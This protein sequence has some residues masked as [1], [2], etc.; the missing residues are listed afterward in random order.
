MNES[1]AFSE[2]GWDTVVL[3]SFGYSYLKVHTSYSTGLLK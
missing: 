2:D 1:R 3:N